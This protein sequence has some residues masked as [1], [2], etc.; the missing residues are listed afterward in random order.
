MAEDLPEM[1]ETAPA[2]APDFVASS[3]GPDIAALIIEAESLAVRWVDGREARFNRFYLRENAVAPGVIDAVTRERDLDTALLPDDLRIT[4]AAIEPMGAGIAVDWAPD[5]A[6]TRHCA[7]WLRRVAERRWRP[8]AGLPA[9]QSWD[10]AQMPAPMDFDGPTVLSADAA[11]QA[12]L[13][14]VARFGLARLTG[15]PDAD[16]LVARVGARVGVV[17]SSSFGFVFTVESKP[18]PDSAAYTSAALTGHTDLPTRECMPGLQLLHC[19]ENT[20]SDGFSTMV[21][22]FRIAEDLRREEPAVFEALA[23]L[24]WVH[25]NRHRDFDYRWSAPIISLDDADGLAEIRFAN[26]LR[27]E[28]D[29]AEAD[30][31]RAYEAVRSF[32]RRAGDPRYVCRYPFRPGD[33]VMFDNRRILHGRDAFDPQG[34]VRRLQGCYVDRDELLSRLRVLSRPG[35]IA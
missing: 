10:A 16:Q 31:P 14:V 32:L 15:L 20:C 8:A 33:L 23:T 9:T 5:G 35:A 4:A 19:R 34:G 17:R 26:N 27:A 1:N 21:D 30:V 2:A 7:D 28:P 13:T 11:L 6:R 29:M 25:T 24:P 18:D 22:G 12:W 3:P